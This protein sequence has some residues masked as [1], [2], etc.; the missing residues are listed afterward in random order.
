MNSACCKKDSA[1]QHSSNAA[2][3]EFLH[4]VFEQRDPSNRYSAVFE[5]A[6]SLPPISVDLNTF[7]IIFRGGICS[8][9]CFRKTRTQFRN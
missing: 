8:V 2:V 3:L 6:A 7:A 9:G 4:D 1:R 5:E